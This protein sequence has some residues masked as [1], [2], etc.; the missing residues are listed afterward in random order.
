MKLQDWNGRYVGA[1]CSRCG[2]TAVHDLADNLVGVDGGSLPGEI[3]RTLRPATEPPRFDW[4]AMEKLS[5]KLGFYSDMQSLQCVDPLVW[6]V[7]GTAKASRGSD[8]S[9]WIEELLSRLGL[10]YKAPEPAEI[11]IRVTEANVAPTATTSP[12]ATRR[13]VRV[14]SRGALTTLVWRTGT[15]TWP[16]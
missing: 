9:A 4:I 15:A 1:E 3:T 5:E 8:R 2:I 6:S 10:S 13:P 7:F 12:S 11:S 14:P 16:G